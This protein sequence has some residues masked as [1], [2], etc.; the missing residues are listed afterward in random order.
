MAVHWRCMLWGGGGMFAVVD[1][2][3]GRQD[4]VG[5]VGVGVIW[6]IWVYAGL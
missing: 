6:G 1:T 3:L 2:V 5:G 4:N